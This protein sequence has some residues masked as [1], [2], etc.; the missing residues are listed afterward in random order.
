MTRRASFEPTLPYRWV[1][2]PYAWIGAFPGF[3]ERTDSPIIFCSCQR[4]AILNRLAL[5]P[6]GINGCQMIRTGFALP[7]TEDFPWDFWNPILEGGAKSNEDFTSA[8][9]FRDQLCHECNRRVPPTDALVPPSTDAFSTLLRAYTRKKA[10]E[11]GVDLSEG[12]ILE[13]WAVPE[14]REIVP[15]DPLIYRRSDEPWG[16]HWEQLL[17]RHDRW[18]KVKRRVA[19]LVRRLTRDAFG[20]PGRGPALTSE[21]ILYLRTVSAFPNNSVERHFRPKGFRGL[22]LDIFLPEFKIGIEYQG[23]QHFVPLDHFGGDEALRK[24]QERDARKQEAFRTIGIEIVYFE[25][26]VTFISEDNIRSKVNQ[27]R[28][29]M[30]GQVHRSAERHRG[31]MA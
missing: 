11:I 14:L 26:N 31:M 13:E 29:R 7:D 8:L 3:Q 1:N 6:P 10:F 25:G 9:Q 12:R 22:S 2:Y 23:D 16:S 30:S 28:Q 5:W 18:S 19:S 24:T 15:Y 4:R 27:L 20:F 17:E 21:T